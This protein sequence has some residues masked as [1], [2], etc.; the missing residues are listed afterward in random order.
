MLRYSSSSSIV[1]LNPVLLLWLLFP[2]VSS[3]SLYSLGCQI[4]FVLRRKT[5]LERTR[6]LATNHVLRYSGGR[7]IHSKN[8]LQSFG[9]VRVARSNWLISCDTMINQFSKK[10]RWHHSP[11]F[12][13]N[14]S[15]CHPLLNMRAKVSV[16]SGRPGR[17]RWHVEVNVI[18][19]RFQFPSNFN[20]ILVF[21]LEK[22]RI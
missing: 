10:F 13:R 14:I 5:R 15:A 1:G 12:S 7:K 19:F 20:Q 11:S 17:V 6:N 9:F 18:F 8:S 21:A 22:Y 16:L 2:A 3:I 4:I